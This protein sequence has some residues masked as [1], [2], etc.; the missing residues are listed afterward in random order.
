MYKY[1][2][3]QIRFEDFGQPVG[4]HMSPNN[5]WIKR[6][7]SIPWDE[8]EHR[9]AELFKNRKGNVAKPLRLALGA[10][11]IQS[12]Y[13]FSDEETVLQIQEGPY[14]QFFCGFPQYE[15]KQPFD[16]SLMVYFRKRL[17]LEIL[18]EI[19]ELIIRKA[20]KESEEERHDDR[21][22]SGKPQSPQNSGTM[23]VDAT[24]APS[25]I[26]YPQDTELLNE[27]RENTET[28]IDGMHEAK[29]GKRPRTYRKLAHKNYLKFA[30][31]KKRTR[32][33]IRRSVRQQL[34]YLKRNLGVIDQMLSKGKALSK[35]QQK[36][37]ETIRA[38]Y[39]QQKT[40]YDNK[41]HSVKDRIV[42]LSQP[43]LRPV[44]RG[45]A[46]NPVEFGAKLDISVVDGFTR[47]EKQSFDSYN[48]STCL[49]EEIERYKAREGCYPKRV[50]AD[51]IYR[52]R[53]N[54]S[55]CKGRGIRLSGPALGRPRKDAVVD[56][57]LEYTD[58]CDRVEVER[59]FSLAKR[60]CGLG[61]IMTKL[62]IT[63]EHVVAMSILLLNLRKV[64]SAFLRSLF[65]W[66]FLPCTIKNQPLFS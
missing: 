19:N 16:P 3:G 26:K 47:L 32:K 13:G 36:R 18:G 11:I 63:T 55:C 34:G 29:D 40:M 14:L 31:S 59:K 52:N 62:Q 2:S 8:I 39:K 42:S 65:N 24:C 57:K 49:K 60:K 28:M 45:K 12:E 4:M 48:E 64:L 56:R 50:L 30:R 38:L 35:Q 53:A 1:A 54:W 9:Y 61:L 27:A 5:R 22:D 41:V 15:Y 46:K 43:Y 7:E 17:T 6:A 66:M 10:C 20:K 21:N 25:N 51:K 44:V 37:L 23:I 58:I 33:Q